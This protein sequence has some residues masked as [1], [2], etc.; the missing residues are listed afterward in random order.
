MNTKIPRGGTARHRAELEKKRKN[1]IVVKESKKTN[2]GKVSEVEEEDPYLKHLSNDNANYA[3]EFSEESDIDEESEKPEETPK[4]SK[5]N[6]ENN[7]AKQT[8]IQQKKET[9]VNDE[10][11][12]EVGE[13]SD[14]DEE[15]EKPEET[16]KKSKRNQENN[17]A[18]Q[19]RIQQ[20]KE[21]V[22]N[23]E[24]GNEVGKES[25][26]DEEPV[27]T[28]KKSERNQ[29]N[30]V[31]KQTRSQRKKQPAVDDENSNEIREEVMN[32]ESATEVSPKKSKGN[33]ENKF[34]KQTR[35]QQKKKPVV[36][37]EKSN[38]S[39]K[40]T[41]SHVKRRKP[42]VLD[43]SDDDSRASEDEEDVNEDENEMTASEDEPEPK[44]KAPKVESMKSSKDSYY[45]E[46]EDLEIVKM[47]WKL[48]RKQ[49]LSKIKGNDCW[50]AFEKSNTI[51]RPWQSMRNRFIKHILKNITD[52]PMIRA[53]VADKILM[54]ALVPDAER[55]KLVQE[56]KVLN[57]NC[58]N[59]EK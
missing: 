7:V 46:E 36:E 10:N 5:R 50:K 39:N 23:D 52:Y 32:E 16:P 4:K 54:A 57:D 27:K 19:T 45:T 58:T 6:Q 51:D 33:K 55:K 28:P 38:S 15:S 59:A 48:L 49:P 12:N 34:F 11:G 2:N 22:V 14:M 13:E 21:T 24:N 9:V 20:K 18:K 56:L 40:V 25:D 42:V 1:K 44:T 17:V 35:S 37:E 47:V 30:N 43:S 3:A 53:D 31:A 29:G 8:R 41:Q 26:M